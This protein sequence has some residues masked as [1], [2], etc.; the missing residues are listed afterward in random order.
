MTE[1]EIGKLKEEWEQLRD[2]ARGL[3]IEWLHALCL[4]RGA[5]A[6]ERLTEVVGRA[7]VGKEVSG[8]KPGH[9]H[10]FNGGAGAARWRKV[11]CLICGVRLRGDGTVEER[12]EREEGESE[13]KPN[14]AAGTGVVVGDGTIS[15]ASTDRN[16][17]KHPR[18]VMSV[19]TITSGGGHYHLF[20]C[21]DC[22]TL[23]V[24]AHIAGESAEVEQ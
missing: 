10:R 5:L 16:V 24:G 7:G 11:V 22:G 14:G 9:V 13:P 2:L 6:V 8:P 19:V 21:R 12:E 15:G 4:L 3:R 1:D 17:C 20:N 18:V 23:N